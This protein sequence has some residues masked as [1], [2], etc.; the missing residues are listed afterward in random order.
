VMHVVIRT[1]SDPVSLA[2]E[3]RPIIDRVDPTVPITRVRTMEDIVAAS[4]AQMTF[5]MTL[6]AIAAVVALVLG[7]VGVYGVINYVVSQRVPE[8]GVRL[9]LGAQPGHVRRIVLRQGLA[10][11]LVGVIV[12]IA[13]AA[14]ATRLMESMLFEVSARDPLTFGLVAAGLIG[15]SAVATYLP[16]RR[17]AAI[18]PVVA[19]RQEA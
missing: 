8:I 14:A 1:G 2:P 18:D 19:L 12:G 10:V 15:V 6:L 17:A 11:A 16:A 3:L 13:L 7:T 9:A 4:M 5:T